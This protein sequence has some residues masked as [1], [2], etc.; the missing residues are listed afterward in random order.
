METRPFIIIYVHQ[1]VSAVKIP[2]SLIP[3]LFVSCYALALLFYYRL[4]GC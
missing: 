2:A 1:P 3:L 4:G